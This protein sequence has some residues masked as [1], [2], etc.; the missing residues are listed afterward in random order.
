[1]VLIYSAGCSLC[2]MK[3]VLLFVLVMVHFVGCASG[4]ATY[5]TKGTPFTQPYSLVSTYNNPTSAPYKPVH[6]IRSADGVLDVTLTVE[7]SRIEI[8]N[9]FSYNARTFCHQGICSSPGPSI[10]V[11]QGDEVTITLINKLEPGAANDTNIY[12]RGLHL[13]RS[14]NIKSSSLSS[15]GTSFVE[16]NSGTPSPE[17]GYGA[18]GY[19]PNP[20]PCN[21]LTGVGGTCK[22]DIN[23]LLEL[24]IYAISIVFT[25]AWFKSPLCSPINPRL[26]RAHCTTFILM[27][28]Q[29]ITIAGTNATAYLA[30]AT[31][32]DDNEEV[33]YQSVVYRFT[34]PVNHPVGVNYYHSN[35]YSS[36]YTVDSDSGQKRYKKNAALHMMEGLVGAFVVQPLNDAATLPATLINMKTYECVF[37]H[38]MLGQN[39]KDISQM[40]N[41]IEITPESDDFSTAWSLA[42]LHAEAGSAVDIASQM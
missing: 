22:A 41:S 35:T 42:R 40:I 10:H 24:Y 14:T 34:V 23:R 6:T 39:G 19:D 38:V 17:E 11:R 36:A 30:T 9:L 37:S 21:S 27:K 25:I 32:R 3:H 15:T 5:L 20:R 28:T 2:G 31:M 16:A 33:L 4:G 18:A 26:L 8:D 12:I 7:I 29:N 1:M 13:M